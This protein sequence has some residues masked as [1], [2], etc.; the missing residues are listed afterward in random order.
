MPQEVYD[1]GADL[2][3]DA[4]IIHVWKKGVPPNTT[5]AAATPPQSTDSRRLRTASTRGG[6]DVGS[7]HT[8]GGA[9]ADGDDGPPRGKGWWQ[10]E[11]AE[12]VG[13]GYYAVLSSPW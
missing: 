12:V 13:A 3:R 11:L 8:R 1:D 2:P 10:D 7:R 6:M 5:A 4:V 9:P